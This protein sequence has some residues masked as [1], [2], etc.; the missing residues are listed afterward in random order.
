MTPASLLWSQLLLPHPNDPQFFSVDSDPIHKTKLIQ[1]GPDPGP[2]WAS[3]RASTGSPQSSSL[4]TTAASV[5]SH[6]SSHTV[7]HWPLWRTSTLPAQRLWPPTNRTFTISKYKAVTMRDERW[8]DE[9]SIYCI[10]KR[11]NWNGTHQSSIQV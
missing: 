9:S 8:R 10:T 7:P 5:I 11:D 4:H 6:S 3:P 1:I 2:K